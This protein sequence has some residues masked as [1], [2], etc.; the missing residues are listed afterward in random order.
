MGLR[1]VL[2]A[3]V[4]LCAVAAS[5]SG[6]AMA[7]H[8]SATANTTTIKAVAPTPKFQI[9]RYV[10]TTLRWDKD[11]YSVASGGTLHILNL[12]ADEGPHTFTIVA[13]KDLPRTLEQMM[14]CN[15][16]NKLARAHGADPQ[17]NAPPKFQFLENGVGT[18][19]PP[20]VNQ[21]GDSGVTGQGKKGESI[22]L[23][24]TAPAGTK[25]Y[26]VCLIH[27]WMQAVVNVT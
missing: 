13:R 12:A 2:L 7:G 3:V 25:L 17:S 18:K 20:K 10:Q 26:F 15:I 11:S 8:R 4:G 19:K 6:V 14:N 9:N 5:V 1:K 22:D 27:P 24:V 23:K 21:P 16:C